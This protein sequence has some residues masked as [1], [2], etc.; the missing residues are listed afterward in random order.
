MT[1]YFLPR[2]KFKKKSVW[3]TRVNFGLVKFELFCWSM[4]RVENFVPRQPYGR[5]FI[6]ILEIGNFKKRKTKT[7]TKMKMKSELIKLKLN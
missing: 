5:K 7:K 6:R 4:R 1:G 2:W 3:R